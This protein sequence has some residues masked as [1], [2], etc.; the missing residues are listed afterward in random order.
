MLTTALYP[1]SAPSETLSDVSAGCV[2]LSD[3]GA[4]VAR[5]R[6]ANR[7]TAM[8]ILLVAIAQV[9][10]LSAGWMT[11]WPQYTTHYN[12]LAEAFVR[13]QCSLLFR[14]DPAHLALPDPYDPVANGIYR[15]R[16]GRARYD[17]VRWEVLS[18]L[19]PRSGPAA[20]AGQ[21]AGRPLCDRR[22]ISRLHVHVRRH[23]VQRAAAAQLVGPVLR[24][25]AA[26]DAAAGDCHCRALHA[27]ALH[28]GAFGGVRGRDPG[29]Q[30]FLL[31]GLYAVCG[32]RHF[33]GRARLVLAGLCWA[34]AAGSRASLAIALA[35][36]SALVAWRIVRHGW[37]QSRRVDFISLAAFG[38]PL[39][40]GAVLLG[41]YN[42]ARF[43][44]WREFG[45]RFQLTNNN[46]YHS[47]PR[48]F[49]PANAVPGMYSYLLRPIQLHDHF[50]FVEAKPGEGRFPSFIRLPPHY[51][52]DEP[53]AGLLIVTPFLWLAVIPVCR[54][55]RSIVDGH[56]NAGHILPRPVLRERA[57]VRARF[58]PLSRS[59]HEPSAH[60]RSMKGTD[61]KHVSACHPE[62]SEGSP[63]VAAGRDSSQAQDDGLRPS[64]PFQ[65]ST[66][67]GDQRLDPARRDLRSWPELGPALSSGRLPARLRGCPVH[68]RLDHALLVR[69]D[70][71][72][73]DR[74]GCRV[75]AARPRHGRRACRARRMFRAIAGTLAG[76][77]IVLGVLLGITGYY[78]HFRRYHRHLFG[79]ISYWAH[80]DEQ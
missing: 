26:L 8:G 45:Q 61:H 38:T 28:A 17:P 19:G 15:L 10:V 37:R 67:R 54:L 71:V 29:G 39:A 41:A 75:L 32:A 65:S 12:R 24:G 74:G 27:A 64:A 47:I 11:Y 23:A 60:P 49:Q 35:G 14:P 33:P 59:H 44:N 52:Y 22:S 69:P 57:G 68:A 48:L 6:E 5:R 43:G 16:A 46:N 51:E 18:L 77:S 30:C 70:A 66:G 78:Q 62:R 9:W 72:P 58:C 1:T 53:I 36:L 4:A 7:L 56:S 21:G 13:G 42:V 2:P 55:A 31:A 20:G 79:G 63:G 34:L 73:D 50:P 76:W 40:A 25:C 80:E 3:R